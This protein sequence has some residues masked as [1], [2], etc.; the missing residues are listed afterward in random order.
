MKVYLLMPALT[1]LLIRIV[2]DDLACRTNKDELL[3]SQEEG[4]SM[5]DF[6]DEE[7]EKLLSK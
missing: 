4:G 3:A 7:L 5:E 1:C 2:N 6:S